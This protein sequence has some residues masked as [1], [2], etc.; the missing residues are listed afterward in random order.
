MLEKLYIRLKSEEIT[1]I[2]V[3]IAIFLDL[4]SVERKSTRI[5]IG[6]KAY[7]NRIPK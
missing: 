4:P 2:K 7:H 5:T 1:A 6:S 3:M